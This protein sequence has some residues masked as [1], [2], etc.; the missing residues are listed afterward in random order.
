MQV[1]MGSEDCAYPNGILNGQHLTDVRIGI[2]R[3]TEHQCIVAACLDTSRLF[4]DGKFGVQTEVAVFCGLSLFV[5][6]SNVIRTSGNAILAA[7]AAGIVH[8][9]DVGGRINVR[10]A[11]RADS[12]ARRLGTLLTGHADILAVA[13]C[14]V[15]RRLA[16]ERH[17]K[18]A[19]RNVIGLRA[20]F[21]ACSAADTFVLIEDHRKPRLISA[22]IAG[23]CFLLIQ[24]NCGDGSE[25]CAGK[26]FSTVYCHDFSPRPDPGPLGTVT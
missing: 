12:D 20:R 5:N 13:R 4:S 7:D 17:A 2:V 26:E 25:G 1:R 22:D 10:S 6:E 18:L 14:S 11:C 8:G 21:L 3:I 23:L 16:L 9:H 15:Q 19:G 24:Q